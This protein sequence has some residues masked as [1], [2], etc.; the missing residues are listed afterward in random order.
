[1]SEQDIP[2]YGAE[3]Q[4]H[5]L[6]L[7]VP[8]VLNLLGEHLYSEPRVVL[9]ELIQNAHDSCRR[10]LVE[11]PHLP[12]DYRPRIDITID[13]HL[14]RLTIRDNGS[15]LTEQEIHD[16]LS[17]I[18]RGYTGELRERMQFADR[19]EVLML[20]GQFGLGLLS[21]FLVADY[22]EMHTRSFQAGEP[23]WCWASAG[24]GH[25]ALVPSDRSKPGSTLALSLKLAGEF[26]LN[27]SIVREA[28]RTYADFLQIPIY[29]DGGDSPVNMR[30]APWHV[31]AGVQAYRRFIVEHFDVDEP[32][33][34]I[35]LHDHIETIKEANAECDEVATPLQGVLF[36]PAGSSTS[37]REHGDVKVYIRRMHI[38][39]EDRE[40]LPGWARFVRGVID[41]PVL[42][43][44]ASREQ[45]RR[46]EA[47]YHIQDILAEQLVTYIDDLAGRDPAL[48]RD[49]VSAHND[50]IKAQ[51]LEY[52][53][54]FAAVCDLV[55]FDTSQ[56]RLTLPQCSGAGDGDIYY[57]VDG[58]GAL[59]EKMLYE[60]RGLTVIDAGRPGE[61]A[62]LKAY[63][64]AHPNVNVH[65]MAPGAGF[66]FSEVDDPDRR[67]EPL[68]RY[69]TDQGIPVRVASFE[70]AGIPAVLIYPPNYDHIAEASAAL[71]SG[72]IG[73]SV[74]SLVE[75]YVQMNAQSGADNQGVL[76]LN[77]ANSLLLR[78][79]RL[80]DGGQGV[81]D[82][83]KHKPPSLQWP[84][85]GGERYNPYRIGSSTGQ[86][87]VTAA[88]EIIYHN[89]RLFA[90]RTLTPK[91]ARQGFDMIG[92]SLD[93]LVKVLEEAG[94]GSGVGSSA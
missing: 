20:V 4:K 22:V 59:Q 39:G 66:V 68:T 16:F 6:N 13:A 54:L 14:R 29:L 58:C 67:W 9:R 74:A 10:R 19:E 77:A 69:Y 32:L 75:A 55:T 31:D 35:P 83:E 1:M 42:K 70:P 49:I 82:G 17:T 48:W 60:A 15:G 5:P 63:A 92:Y 50:V 7:H 88:L 87:A 52:S 94:R 34:V 78:L 28:I 24:E 72:E 47:F 91:E 45:V 76:Y 90:G 30:D 3:E 86:N 12:K 8:G 62:F 64:S 38:T 85:Q 33:A 26:L 71:E 11:D 21:T 46:D 18:G 51:S 65:Q 89:A 56:G 57:L 73:G 44:T 27:R 79:L 2:R 25:Y 36:I 81:G 23:A 80:G 53:R 37:A 43:P 61:E 40:L 93:Q 84:R 41:C